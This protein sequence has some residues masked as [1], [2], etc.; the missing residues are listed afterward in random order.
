MTEHFL[1]YE[2]F[3]THDKRKRVGDLPER[4]E[5]SVLGHNGFTLT[6]NGWELKDAAVLFTTPL[7]HYDGGYQACE[8]FIAGRR[9]MQPSR[10]VTMVTSASFD[11]PSEIGGGRILAELADDLQNE[12]SE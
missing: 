7:G 5:F 2:I 12:D 9:S 8:A 1:D 4:A 3:Y 10:P 11:T 6:D